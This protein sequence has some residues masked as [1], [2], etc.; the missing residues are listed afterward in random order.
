MMAMSEV[1]PDAEY[2]K[3][4]AGYDFGV[5]PS[6]YVK[7]KSLQPLYDSDGNGVFNQDEVEE[8]LAAMANLDRDTRAA[9]WQMSNKSWKPEGNPFDYRIG[10][11][12]YDALNEKAEDDGSSAGY[13][14]IMLPYAE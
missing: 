11:E 4:L 7:F 8:V 3:L 14:G 10:Q 6:D 13:G 12:I 2:E 5:T 1:M 9:L